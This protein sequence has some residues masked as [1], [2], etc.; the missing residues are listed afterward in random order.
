[1]TGVF[2]KQLCDRCLS[3]LS[4]SEYKNFVICSIVKRLYF[5]LK[6]LSA[7]SVTVNGCLPERNAIETIDIHSNLALF[8]S[9]FLVMCLQRVS[10]KRCNAE[11]NT[12]IVTY[13]CLNEMRVLATQL[14]L[15]VSKLLINQPCPSPQW[16]SAALS[17]LH[18]YL[19]PWL[20]ALR[21]KLSSNE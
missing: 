2:W 15:W 4:M 11:C 19:L 9:V 3:V 16:R 18:S 8:I 1:M 21:W 6:M 14:K 5:K 10:H 20:Y 17:L 7:D 12:Q 13:S